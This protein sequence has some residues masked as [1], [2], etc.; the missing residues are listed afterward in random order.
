MFTYANGVMELVVGTGN[1]VFVFTNGAK[2]IGRL[3]S[4]TTPT[5]IYYDSTADLTLLTG[6][7]YTM[8][9]MD[10]LIMTSVPDGTRHLIS[11][12]DDGLGNYNLDI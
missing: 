8:I 4:V 2:A 12:V 6:T 1:M 3:S 5:T 7:H 9:P 11:L 10:K